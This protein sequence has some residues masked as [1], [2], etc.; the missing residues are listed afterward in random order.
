[1]SNLTSNFSDL[2]LPKIKNGSSRSKLS[3]FRSAPSLLA[4]ASSN[5]KSK[6]YRAATPFVRT[7]SEHSSLVKQPEFLSRSSARSSAK[8]LSPLPE[9]ESIKKP[10]CKASSSSAFTL[11][12]VPSK[13]FKVL[14][15]IQPLS[16][17]VEESLA[18]DVSSLNIKPTLSSSFTLPSLANASLEELEC[19]LLNKDKQLSSLAHVIK[20]NRLS[21]LE[22]LVLH[23]PHFFENLIKKDI[24]TLE[25]LS[26]TSVTFRVSDR[27]ADVLSFL[28]Y[29]HPSILDNWI[30]SGFVEMDDLIGLQGYDYK[31][32]FNVYALKNPEGL[33]KLINRS[34]SSALSVG[35]AQFEKGAPP[36]A[37]LLEVCP[38][39]FLRWIYEYKVISS[40]ECD[41]IIYFRRSFNRDTQPSVTSL[42]SEFYFRYGITIEEAYVKGFS[43]KDSRKT[44][45]VYAKYSEGGQTWFDTISGPSN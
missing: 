16:A 15:P 14:P 25:E 19:W 7:A 21:V 1:M 8:V 37:V 32:I 43:V 10:S 12:G 44:C 29:N 3:S 13:N 33:I 23:N 24:V 11:S 36:L 40:E 26:T 22:D 31:S 30:D 41:S 9:C 5:A 38:N 45:A 27:P 18:S 39:E 17:V 34:G 6:K 42:S 2:S 4:Q 28:I 20:K 35:T